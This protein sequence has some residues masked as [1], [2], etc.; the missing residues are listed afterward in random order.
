MKKTTLIVTALLALT[1]VVSTGCGA[2]SSALDG[3]VTQ[4]NG[5]LQKAVAVDAQVQ[6]DALRLSKVPY[7]RYGAKQ[8]GKMAA[9]LRAQLATE[10]VE[11]QA[12]RQALAS[13]AGLD[14]KAD[15]KQ[16]ALL[17]IAAID[18]RIKIADQ[19][20]ALYAETAK[21][22]AAVVNKH[23]GST[24]I[25][26]PTAQIDAIGSQIAS[27]TA[28]ASAQSKAASDYFQAHNLGN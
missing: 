3:V 21:V 18:T 27:L 10:K 11:L 26:A 7:S 24:A 2:S 25:S 9:A 14:L 13:V 28:Q 23:A 17:E 19:G 15:F 1:L 6:S 4:V 22:Y 20:A 5:H 12:A 16:Y 8:A